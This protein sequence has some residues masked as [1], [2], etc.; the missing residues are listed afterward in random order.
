MKKKREKNNL[1]HNPYDLILYYD[2]FFVYY[3][4]NLKFELVPLQDLQEHLDIES[5]EE[6]K[7]WYS[8]INV[9]NTFNR[10]GRGLDGDGEFQQLLL[11]PAK[12]QNKGTF[13]CTEFTIK[14]KQNPNECQN[15]DVMSNSWGYRSCS[16]EGELRS[17]V[18]CIKCLSFFERKESKTKK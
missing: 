17:R 4:H 6:F 12:K 1:K 10:W 8:L 14:Q 5:I 7:K 9:Q 3:G 16:K 13:P 18:K 2:D 15:L 11:Y